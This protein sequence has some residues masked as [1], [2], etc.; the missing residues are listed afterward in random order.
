MC[1]V[2]NYIL[3]MVGI[4]NFMLWVLCRKFFSLIPYTPHFHPHGGSAYQSII[5]LI[6]KHFFKNLARIRNWRK[7]NDLEPLRKER[8]VWIKL[9][10][11]QE[12]LT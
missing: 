11:A 10:S 3:K 5:I 8:F 4:V 1:W 9:S 7:Y 2:L 12:S 6:S